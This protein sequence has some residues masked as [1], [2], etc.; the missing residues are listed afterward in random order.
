MSYN[1]FLDDIRYPLG[2]YEYTRFPALKELTF[3]IVR[4]YDEFVDIITKTGLPDFISFDHDLMDSEVWVPIKGYENLYEVS[5]FGRVRSFPR[6]TT[7]GGILSPSKT[8]GGLVVM[9]RNSGNDC[10]RRVHRLVGEHFIL[11]INNHPQINHKDG[12]RWNNHLNNLEWCTNSENI[13]HSHD[14]LNR[15]F[16]AY[17]ENH[18]NSIV[19]SKYDKNMNYLGTYGSVNEAGRQNNIPFTNIAKCAR[20]ERKTAGK[21]IWKYDNKEVTEKSTIE[22]IPLSEKNYI[23]RF[24]I[25]S[26]CEKTGYECAKWLVSYCIDN[27]LKLPSYYVHSMNPVGAENIHGMMASYYKFAQ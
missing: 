13:K 25:P 21:F 8:E 11:N 1:L 18:E 19:V 16:T 6:N 27:K 20:N 15:E 22:H 10:K 24:F 5:S 7:N 3:H 14:F 26:Y 17:G 12:N 23:S 2:A 9:L 4:N